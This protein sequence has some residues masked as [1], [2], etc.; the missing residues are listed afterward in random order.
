M[1]SVSKG[2]RRRWSCVFVLALATLGLPL[3]AGSAASPDAIV[4]TWLTDD[5]DSKVA[6]EAAKAPDGGA[7]YNGKVV[8]LKAPTRDGKPL[9][10]ANNEDAALRE[11]PI[12]GLEIVSGFKPDGAGGWTGG[13][14]YSPRGGKRY[15]AQISLGD[16][17]RLQIKVKAGL[18]S[19]TVAW[20]R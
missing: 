3:P 15:P 8:W 9:R 13:T 17:G 1:R 10:D 12:M 19:R 5:G 6:I 4:G 20:A 2:L 14:V 7:V 18:V 16:D 11:R